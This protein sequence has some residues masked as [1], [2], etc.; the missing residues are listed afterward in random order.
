MLVVSNACPK[1]VDRVREGPGGVSRFSFR[2][3]TYPSLEDD[4]FD[5]DVFCN[6]CP[7]APDLGVW[8]PEGEFGA[9]L[10][11]DRLGVGADK[12]YGEVVT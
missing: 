8:P 7:P 12:E 3:T 10:S 5:E 6:G 1:S 4:R 9:E 11:G 2:I